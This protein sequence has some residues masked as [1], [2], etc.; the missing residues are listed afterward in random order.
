MSSSADRESI[1]AKYL[2]LGS[3]SRSATSGADRPMKGDGARSAAAPDAVVA[4]VS[5]P[6]SSPPF[7]PGRTARHGPIPGASS[8]LLA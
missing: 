7:R 6:L 2:F 4:P 5:L 3:P 8:S 1:T